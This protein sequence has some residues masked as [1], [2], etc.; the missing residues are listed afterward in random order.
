MSDEEVSDTKTIAGLEILRVPLP[1][2][3]EHVYAQRHGQRVLIL[4]DT[5]PDPEAQPI[6]ARYSATEP[7]ADDAPAAPTE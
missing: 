1:R 4:P 6:I 7:P 3:G 2:D 5:M